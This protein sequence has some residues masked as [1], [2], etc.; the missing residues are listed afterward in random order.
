MNFLERLK[1]LEG[2]YL[3]L[4]YAGGTEYG[5]LVYVGQDFIEFDVI[6]VTTM[7]YRETLFTNGRLVLEVMTGGSDIQRIVAEVCAKIAV[8]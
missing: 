5:K 1:Q 3:F 6:D 8:D 7:E 4:K 2:Q